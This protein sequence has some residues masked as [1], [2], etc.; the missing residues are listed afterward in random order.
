MTA[1]GAVCGLQLL[2]FRLLTRSERA[3]RRLADTST[4]VCRKLPCHWLHQRVH[5]PQ[6]ALSRL[7]ER[8]DRVIC[9]AAAI[10]AREVAA[11]ALMVAAS[12]DVHCADDDLSADAVSSRWVPS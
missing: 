4:A 8:Q 1:L 6:G 11:M 12:S 3:Q 10:L 5:H 2:A 7:R 9:L